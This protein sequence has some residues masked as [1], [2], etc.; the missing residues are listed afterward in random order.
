[1]I[2]L[3]VLGCANHREA[4]RKSVQLYLGL[5]QRAVVTLYGMPSKAEGNPDEGN[6]S[7][8]YDNH[9]EGSEGKSDFQHWTEDELVWEYEKIDL[10]ITFRHTQAGMG[11]ED[12][13][14]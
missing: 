1:M 10:K 4:R 2:A 14:N 5:S 7:R 9:Q 3:V 12:L 13:V 11:R 8:D 6:P